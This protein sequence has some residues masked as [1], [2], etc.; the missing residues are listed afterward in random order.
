MVK[1]FLVTMM[2]IGILNTVSFSTS[3]DD[4]K[5]CCVMNM[6]DRNIIY[7]KEGNYTQSVASISK[8]MTAIIAIENGNL[9][10]TIIVEKDIDQIEGSLLYLEVGEKYTL[11]DLLYGLLLRS[12][13]DAAYLIANHI[14]GSEEEFVQLM[15]KKAKALGMCNSTFSNASGLDEINANIS[16][17]CDIALLTSYAMNNATFKKISATRLYRPNNKTT[18]INKNRFL[19]LYK[20]ATGGKT[21]YTKKAKRTL[22]TTS[23]Q[24]D[25]EI[26][27]VTLRA[28]DDFN[29]HKDLHEEAYLKFTQK[30]I[31]KKGNYKYK[32]KI[33]HINEDIYQTLEKGNNEKIKVETNYDKDLEVI[34]KVKDKETKYSFEVTNE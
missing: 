31:I 26:V 6:K 17:S 19:K 5:S 27:V 22:V 3:V 14:S 33:I 24:K 7:E 1:Y 11:E 8:I 16:S 12:G 9:K 23:K 10:D 4:T 13:N 32:D 25:M 18:W 20:N 21:G 2:F 34:V 30:K 28:S 15:N 29:L